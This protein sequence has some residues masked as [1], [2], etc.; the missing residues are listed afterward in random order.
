MP[1]FKRLTKD[2]FKIASFIEDLRR[3]E[4]SFQS[5]PEVEGS[6]WHEQVKS[7]YTCI[8]S[9]SINSTIR[10]GYYYYLGTLCEVYSWNEIARNEIRQYF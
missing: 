9:P 10:L 4:V 6:D 1:I 5:L 2:S 7:L 8:S 3:Q